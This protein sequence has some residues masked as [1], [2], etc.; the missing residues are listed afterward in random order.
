[1]TDMLRS[2]LTEGT[3]ARRVAESGGLG[4]VQMAGKTGTTE[5][6]SDA[7][8]VGFSPHV[9]TAVWFGF[10]VPDNSLGR[11]QT[12]ALAAGPVWV[13]Y[14]KAIH[15]ELP[16]RQFEQPESG[17][18]RRKVCSVSGLLPT[19]DCP[20]VVDEL[21]IVGTEPERL[22][23]YHSKKQELEAA[24]LR[25]LEE[26]LDFSDQSNLEMLVAP[27]PERASG[28]V[29]DSTGDQTN[30]SILENPLM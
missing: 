15:A 24:Q 28:G 25:R 8:T 11:Y 19:E 10:V 30:Q 27:V 7:W 16:Y 20:E 1:M 17:I 26:R 21:F 18:I 14:M 3:L 22:C 6:W 2:T 29:P 23:T 13:R 4:P 9:T 12:G 5:N